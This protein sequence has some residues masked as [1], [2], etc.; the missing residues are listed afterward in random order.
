LAEPGEFTYRAYLNDKLDLAQAE[1]VS[2]LIDASTETAARSATRSMAGDFSRRINDLANRTIRLRMLVEATLDFPE[3]DIDFLHQ[4][5]ATQQLSDVHAAVERV[6][7]TARQGALLREGL[8]VVLAGQPNVGKSSLMNALAGAELAIVTP[9]PGTTRDRLSESIQIEGVPLHITDTAGLRDDDH[10]A[11]DVERIGI[12]RSWGAIE[13][14]DLVLFLH[15]LTRVGDDDYEQADRRIASRLPS[16]VPVLQVY[17]K[18]DSPSAREAPPSAL[19]MSAQTGQGLDGL[20]QQLL[21]RAGWQSLPEGLVTARE[22]HVHAL[23]R[24][25]EHLQQAQTHLHPATLALEL[26]AE[27]LR[28]S[29]EALG[30]ITGQFTPDDLLGEIFSRFCIGK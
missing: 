25:A 15:D 12:S 23:R 1:A 29:H 14:A 4:A 13:G 3:E 11:D 16:S 27:E 10:A 9:M 2:D 22:R 19:V 21:E 6:L 20:R 7:A 28:L 17:N 8:R 26:L 5:A 18:A 24:A 30:E